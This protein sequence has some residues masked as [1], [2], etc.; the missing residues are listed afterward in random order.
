MVAVSE[1]K[2]L[3]DLPR[4]KEKT[5]LRFNGP[6]TWV[7]TEKLPLRDREGRIIGIFGI[8]RD[9]TERK[10]DDERINSLLVLQASTSSRS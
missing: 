9:I 6:S 8:L 2:A 1:R 5:S 3:E 7:L 4:K 10:R